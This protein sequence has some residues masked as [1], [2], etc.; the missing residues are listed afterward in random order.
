MTEFNVKQETQNCIQWIK[1]WFDNQSGN[2]RGI[3]IGISGGKDST[4]AAQLCAEAIGKSNMLGISMPN[5]K[6]SDISDSTVVCNHIGINYKIIN[7]AG[8]YDSLQKAIECEDITIHNQTRTNIPPRIRMTALYAI[9][10]ELGY[11]VCGTGNLSEMYVGYTTKWG[12]TAC[13]FNPLANFT[14]DEVVQIGDEL[15]LPYDLVHKT[16]SDGLCGKTDEDN[17]GFSY[18]ILNRYIRDGVCEDE[19]IKKSIEKKHLYNNHKLNMIP[20]FMR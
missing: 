14:S 5:G 13:D 2:A 7:I 20:T 3:V 12:D 15:G 11:R 8:M 6:Q 16:P 9:A 4:V 10:Q 18:E 1:N 17:L 19:N